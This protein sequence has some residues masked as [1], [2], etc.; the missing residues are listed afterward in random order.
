MR[1]VLHLMGDWA[2]VMLLEKAMAKSK[3]FGSYEALEGGHVA[4]ALF[5][6]TGQPCT[7]WKWSAISEWTAKTVGASSSDRKSVGF[8]I[9]DEKASK[10]AFFD[11]LVM[12]VTEGRFIGAGSDGE[13]KQTKGDRAGAGIVPGR[14]LKV[15]SVH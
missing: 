5:L 14:C 2:K 11:K 9:S 8:R 15:Y 13:D 7:R 1:S 4:Y 6:L 3:Y 12:W 10:A